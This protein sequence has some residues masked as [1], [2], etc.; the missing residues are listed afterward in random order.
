MFEDNEKDLKSTNEFVDNGS[1]SSNHTANGSFTPKDKIDSNELEN[2][3]TPKDPDQIPS[4]NEIVENL[5]TLPEKSA[6]DYL[7]TSFFCLL[8][9]FGGYV[10]GY[11]TGTISGFV[12]MTDF[13]RRFGS[14]DNGE[15]VLTNIRTGLI[16]AI[17]NIGCAVGGIFL[18]KIGDVEV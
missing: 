16:V 8:I 7:S 10:F 1:N 2:H 13:K 18:S 17:F 15:Y 9:A 4:A 6:K 3:E 11:D 12:N 5:P 14:L